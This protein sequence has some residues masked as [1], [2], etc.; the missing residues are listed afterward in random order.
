[1]E[2]NS[3]RV[4]GIDLDSMRETA[5]AKGS[6]MVTVRGRRKERGTD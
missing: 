6:Q 1:M 5:M 2:R 3:A 4:K